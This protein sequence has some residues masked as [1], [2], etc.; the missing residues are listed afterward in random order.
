M[1]TGPVLC[2]SCADSHSCSEFIDVLVVPCPKDSAL[3][4]SVPHTLAF[5]FSLS[6]TIVFELCECVC[7]CMYDI[8]VPFRNQQFKVTYLLCPVVRLS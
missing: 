5:I 7:V 1:V 2:R 4:S 8:E 3:H 6:S